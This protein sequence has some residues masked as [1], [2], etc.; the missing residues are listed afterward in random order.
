MGSIDSYKKIT[1]DLKQKIKDRDEE[2]VR[3]KKLYSLKL[4]VA[5]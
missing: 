1:L 5:G 3:Y 2:F 4:I